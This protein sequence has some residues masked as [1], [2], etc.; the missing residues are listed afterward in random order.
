MDSDA[1]VYVICMLEPRDIIAF[2]LVNKSMNDKV[3]SKDVMNAI[4]DALGI[5]SRIYKDIQHIRQEE[6]KR[7]WL[8]CETQ[9]YLTTTGHSGQL[10]EWMTKNLLECDQEQ[11]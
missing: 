10:L 2:G 11:L 1:F 3:R 4:A 6:L 8:H 9:I 5:D 7:C